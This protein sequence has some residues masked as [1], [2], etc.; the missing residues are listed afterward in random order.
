MAKVQIK[1]QVVGHRIFS[2]SGEIDVKTDYLNGMVYLNPPGDACGIQILRE[3]AAATEK[4]VD[5]MNKYC[6]EEMEG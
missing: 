3:F 5:L 2:N 1:T 6:P 4:A